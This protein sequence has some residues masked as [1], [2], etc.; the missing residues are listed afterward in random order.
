MFDPEMGNER[1]RELDGR[2]DLEKPDN[3]AIEPHSSSF[4]SNQ[5]KETGLV[6]KSLQPAAK[7]TSRSTSSEEAVRATMM[8]ETLCGVIRVLLGATNSGGVL[9]PMAGGVF[10]K[11]LMLT[12][13][14]ASLISLVAS[15]P[16]LT[17]SCKSISTK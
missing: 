7:A 5:A 13:R 3:Q 4:F 2:V 14:S 9:P 11:A 16:S 12:A 8:T 15:I 1:L 10:A 17:G 6:K